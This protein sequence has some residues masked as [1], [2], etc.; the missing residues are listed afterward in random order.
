MK[1][2]MEEVFKKIGFKGGM[3]GYML[4]E[5]ELKMEGEVII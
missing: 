2:K 4:R 3:K 1:I 5:L